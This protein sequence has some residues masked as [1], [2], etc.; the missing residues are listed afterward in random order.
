MD[1]NS[2]LHKCHKLC[3][4]PSFFIALIYFSLLKFT[5][6]IVFKL[7]F[8]S[9]IVWFI[10]FFLHLNPTF[11][12]ILSHG[13]VYVLLHLSRNVFSFFVWPPIDLCL[14]RTYISNRWLVWFRIFIKVFDSGSDISLDTSRR[15]SLL[16]FIFFQ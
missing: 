16:N 15:E 6:Q 12:F 2:N 1:I 5:F 14:L 4:F 10:S 11:L 9:H 13:F 3:F 7:N 8:D